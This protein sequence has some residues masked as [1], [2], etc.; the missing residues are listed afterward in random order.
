[1]LVSDAT[2][3]GRD[4]IIVTERDNN[5]GEAAAHKKAFIID[6]PDRRPVLAKREIV[7]L[8]DIRDPNEYL[9]AGRAWATSGSATRSSS[10]T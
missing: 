4:Q 2:A 8:L 3:F 7:D 6:V 9:A 1:M 5:Q 10:R